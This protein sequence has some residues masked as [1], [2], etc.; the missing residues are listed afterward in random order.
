MIDGVVELSVA[1]I[2]GCD[3]VNLYFDCPSVKSLSPTELLF[4]LLE[5][6]QHNNCHL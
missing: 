5:L 6:D 3:T 2:Q 4:D 1:E